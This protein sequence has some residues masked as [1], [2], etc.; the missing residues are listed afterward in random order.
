[1]RQEK[2]WL[3][4]LLANK[5]AVGSLLEYL[6]NTEMR[7]REGTAKRAAEWRETKNGSGWGRPARR[8]MLFKNRKAE[9]P[10]ERYTEQKDTD[11]EIGRIR[12]NRG[13]KAQEK[14]IEDRIT[15]KAVMGKDHRTRR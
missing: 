5:Y 12:K 9:I 8:C 11:G 2:K 13:L 7:S 15:L 10:E 3:A 6:K 4:E 1:M 14:R